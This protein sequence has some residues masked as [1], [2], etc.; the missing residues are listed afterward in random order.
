MLP[1][2]L[3]HLESVCNK[4]G[5]SIDMFEYYIYTNLIFNS[6]SIR[7]TYYMNLLNSLSKNN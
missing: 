7:D 2:T 5:E 4:T 3:S 6:E 1:L